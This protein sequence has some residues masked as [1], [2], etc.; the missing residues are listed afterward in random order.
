MLLDMAYGGT[1]NTSL[2][3]NSISASP[4]LPTQHGYK[5]SFPKY[6]YEQFVKQ[7]GCKTGSSSFSCL[8]S[9]STA[10]LQNASSYVSTASLYGDWAFLPVTDGTLIRDL[11]SRQLKA[12][13]VNGLRVLTSNNAI[14][15]ASFTPGNITTE[16]DL[17]S[18]L[19]LIFPRLSKKEIKSVLS[20]YPSSSLPT[21]EEAPLFATDGVNSPTAIN[22][23]SLATGQQ[24]RAFAIYSE[25]TFV[26]PS[27]WLAEAYASAPKYYFPFSLPPH[28]AG[29]KYQYSVVPSTHAQDLS[30]S[31]Y[32]PDPLL[33]TADF[34]LAFKLIW[35]NFVTKNDPSIAS[36]VA[37]GWSTGDETVNAASRWPVFVGGGGKGSNRLMINLNETWSED[38][39]VANAISLVDGWNWE[40][41]RGARCEFWRKLGKKLPAR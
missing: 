8:V 26:C 27:Y 23:S 37:N 41:G 19:K 33:H 40:G 2:F 9:A 20:T 11:P 10:T 1:L 6:Q 25:T 39:P 5:D 31:V 32:P 13:K 3:V 22:Q 12:K 16:A 15:A 21:S 36:Q 17:T 14:E 18:Y 29:Y 24:Q 28:K 34:S 4:Y 38:V 35:G 7:A 30:A